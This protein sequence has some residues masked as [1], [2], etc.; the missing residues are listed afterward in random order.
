MLVAI[1]LV[2]AAC[3]GGTGDTTTTKTAPGTSAPPTT[4]ETTTTPPAPP[5]SLPITASDSLSADAVAA[6]TV[7]MTELVAEAEEI[8]G[9]PFLEPP[10]IAILDGEE[11]AARVTEIIAEDLDEE[12]LAID[13]RMFALLGMLDE[14]EDLYSLL[15]DLYTEQVAGFY[16]GDT[17]ELVVPAASDGFTALQR[18]TVLH[19]LVHS[20]TDQHFD[21]NTES[22]RRYDTGTGDDAS[23]L[24]ALIEGDA[25]YF[26]LVYLEGLSPIEALEAVTEVF[27]IDT[28][29]LDS[30]PPWLQADLTFPYDQGLTF[31]SDI[32][33]QGGIAGVDRS[34]QQP[35]DTTEQI[36]TPAKYARNEQPVDL[37]PLTVQLMGWDVHDEGSWG[38]WGLRLLFLETLAP[39]MNTQTA[40]GWGND[41]Y[42]V[43]AA[44]EDVAFVMHYKGDTEQD[45]EEVA[46][47]F[48]AHARGPMNAGPAVES[49]GGLLYDSGAIYLFLDRVDD[50]VFVVAA[51]N[52][53]AGADIRTQLGL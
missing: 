46:D 43:F 44:G 42:R 11:F 22:E 50:E 27:T 32:V 29:V 14:G 28:S 48:I 20:L 15:I 4:A 19:E 51:T 10:A 30:S 34:Y 33:A 24:T 38:E 18:I 47:A 17:K 25:T 7:E 52:P 3:T 2:A 5:V 26:Q 9:L 49:G 37:T 8:R 21:F 36:L 13:S 53:V 1:A 6:V 39:G 12:E 41:T 16:D 35:P 40:S 23:A 31:V 45:A